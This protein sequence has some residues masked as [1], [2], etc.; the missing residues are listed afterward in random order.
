MS[1]PSSVSNFPFNRSRLD[2]A[3]RYIPRVATPDSIVQAFLT[4]HLRFEMG[5]PKD[6]ELSVFQWAKGPL[7]GVQ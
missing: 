2:W 4:S 5:F 7:N 3:S 1:A 6:S